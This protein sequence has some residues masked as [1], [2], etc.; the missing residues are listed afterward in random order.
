MTRPDV[1]KSFWASETSGL[2]SSLTILKN[3]LLGTKK[4]QAWTLFL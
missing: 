3:E 4:Y 2:S 1:D